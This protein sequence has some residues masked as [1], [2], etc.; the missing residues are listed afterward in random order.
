MDFQEKG[1]VNDAL[2]KY[3]RDLT[4]DARE[5]KIDPVIGR[6]DEVL[7]V[8]RIL[9]RKTKNNPVLIGEPGVGKT[10]I[11]EGLAQ[12][13]VKGDVPSVLKNKRILELDM[14]SL[15]AG[16]S[17]LG[18]YEARVKAIVN[19]IGK[20]NGE[21][22]LFIDELHLIV[23]AG[24]TGNGGG[25]DVSNLLKPALARGGLK[26]IGATTLNEYRE[27]IEKDAALERRFQKV[28]VKE[29]TVEETISI[30]RGLKE[31][32]EAYHGVKIHDN[33]IVAAADLSNRYITDRFLPDK[34]IDLVDEASATI[35]TELASVPAE[36]DQTNRKVM[37]LEIERAALSKEKDTKS[38]DRLGEVE[39]ELANLKTKQ[40]EL[41]KKWQTEKAKID[42]MNGLKNTIEQLRTELEITQTEGNYK[43][44]GEIQ[45][46]LLPALEKQ[47]TE[48]E[49]ASRDSIL[50]ENV[51]E[52]EIADIVARWT[53]IP[54]DKLVESERAKLITL[55]KTLEENV[56]G[57]REAIEAV[58][59]AILRSRAGIKDPDKPIGS[60]LFLGPTG[61]GKT[62]VARSLAEVMFN[63]AKKMIRFDM[64]EYMEKHSVSKLIGAPPGYVG[65]SEGGRLTEAVRRNPYSIVLFDEVE[66]ANPDVFNILLQVLD[67]GRITDS[68]G[69]TIDFK[70]TIIIMTSNLG[71]EYMLNA[72]K[73]EDINQDLVKAELN[74]HFRPEFLNRI[75][76]IVTFNPLSKEVVREIIEKLL[77][78]LAERLERDNTYY[79][80]F[81]Q[82]VKDDILK[83]GYDRQ[84][85]ARPIKRYIEK[86]VETLLAK[87]IVSGK[88][89]D[90]TKYLID[91][92]DKGEYQLK[93][94]KSLN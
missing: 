75:D 82:K 5:G 8:I 32:F 46:S 39:T 67:E 78:E 70:N 50:T 92:D 11:V 87:E 20:A 26:A 74:K 81:S 79:L 27:Y 24:K 83:N 47:L 43:R 40:D 86:N 68:L 16:A 23:G 73:Q 65:Y 9:S 4:K 76:S 85:G 10:A 94:V 72:E 64:S 88:L 54:M 1:Q 6:E 91:L 51:T 3:T 93:R 41:T 57:Q 22:V 49:L 18:D 56:K 36:L 34:A 14:G 38:R 62:E 71:S 58:S 37:Q 89:K 69:K 48:A 19:E 7:R 59:D 60:F 28:L 29:P 45:Y 61:V 2:A 30:L 55:P 80:T 44:A 13:I 53:N 77:T 84:F 66:K 31:R 17:Y 35:K 52:K 25:M 33:A 63:S 12:R 15:M 21:I 42:K 90:E